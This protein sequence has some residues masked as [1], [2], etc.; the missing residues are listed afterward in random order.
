MVPVPAA[1]GLLTSIS[2]RYPGAVRTGVPAHVSV[3]YPF[4]PADMLTEQVISTLRELFDCASTISVKFDE[5]RRR[6]NFVYLL[7]DPI[8]P[9]EALIRRATQRWPD[10]VP[11]GGKYEA[12]PHLTVAMRTSDD[13]A[14]AIERDVAVEL[15]ISTEL[16]EAWLVIYSGGQW[17]LRERF[18]FGNS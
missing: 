12:K 6:E 3:L 17:T 8:D 7:P 13:T 18:Q 15:P 10:V 11:Y 1:D 2:S 4:L 16:H 5:C 9:L 14:A